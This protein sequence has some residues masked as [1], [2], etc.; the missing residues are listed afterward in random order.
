[1]LHLAREAWAADQE[2]VILAVVA[3]EA[4]LAVKPTLEVDLIQGWLF[5][6]PWTRFFVEPHE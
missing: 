1:M 2:P 5:F 6:L 3:R 4:A